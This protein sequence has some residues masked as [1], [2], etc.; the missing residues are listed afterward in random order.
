MIQ[1]QRNHSGSPNCRQSDNLRAV[2]APGEV[3]SPC[4][5][6]RIEQR[7]SLTGVWIN[8]SRAVCLVAIAALAGQPQIL[9]Y[10]LAAGC[11]RDDVIEDQGHAG[12]GLGSAAITT[13]VSGIRTNLPLEL[14][15][16]I[17]HTHDRLSI[18]SSGGKGK[19]RQRSRAYA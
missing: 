3:R 10:R 14:S 19:P 8:R 5:G 11:F 13:T 6:A 9:S 18:V 12:D 16:N 17:G 2:A 1:T 7:N 4:L 15:R